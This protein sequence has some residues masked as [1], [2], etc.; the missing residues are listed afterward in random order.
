MGVAAMFYRLWERWKALAHL[1]GNFQARLLLSIFYF[2]V[3]SPFG[4]GVRLLSDPLALKKGRLPGWIP[5]SEQKTD[6]WQAARA[7]S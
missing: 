5:R 4:L 2:L 6:T 1:I 3:L 7:Q